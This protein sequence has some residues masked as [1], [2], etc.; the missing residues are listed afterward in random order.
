MRPA[1][2]HD[3]VR[4]PTADDGTARLGELAIEFARL[5]ATQ[6]TPPEFCAAALDAIGPALRATSGAVVFFSAEDAVEA[7]VVAQREWPAPGAQGAVRPARTQ[8]DAARPGAP[9]LPSRSVLDDIRATGRTVLLSDARDSA[10]HAETSIIAM[11]MRSVMASPLQFD[12]RIAGVIHLENAS[13]THAFVEADRRV[14][15]ATGALL[16][17]FLQVGRRLDAALRDSARLSAEAAGREVGELIGDSRS[18]QALRSVIARVAPTDAP[19]LVLGESGTGKELVARALH[20]ASRRSA[21]RMIA[22]NCAAMP[23]SL[24]ESE[25]FGHERGAFTGAIERRIG[26][27]EQADGGT[28]FLD[29]IAELR[30]ELQAKLLRV[31][32]DG[33]FERV[34]GS[35]PV[36]ADVRIVAATHRDL[37]G[38]VAEGRFREDLYY[39]LNVVP[40][41]VPPLRDRADDIPLLADRFFREACAAMGRDVR[42]EPDVLAALS[43]HAFPG[44]V[45][46]LRNL[47]HRLVALAPGDVALAA[48]LPPEIVGT[49]RVALDK[50]PFRR[51]LRA[52]P[53][54]NDELKALR[55]EMQALLDGYVHRLEAEFL[56]RLLDDTGGNVAEAARR[57]GMNRTLF[58]RK[59]KRAEG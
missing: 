48:D 6:S 55:E 22:V 27:F 30:P 31:L 8:D 29:E 33:M 17:P 34:G 19:V 16:S 38:A 43:R 51:F 20:A 35:R 44:N 59:L 4:M 52:T 49:R 11:D 42:P 28:L 56:R 57:A 58:H 54:T 50:D 47:V 26:R 25:L 36:R 12:G 3:G 40:V 23:E 5:F 46:E 10:F 24:M 13:I 1:G 32:Q 2:V 37:E 45:R 53:R 15:E 7:T 14:L 21:G 41:R 9:R 39:R 18:M